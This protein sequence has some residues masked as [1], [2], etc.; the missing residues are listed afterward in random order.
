[1]FKMRLKKN[2]N[3]TQSLF[4]HN[5]P[6]YAQIVITQLRIVLSDLNSHLF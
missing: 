5:I 4:N 6:R 3:T 2:S 1:M